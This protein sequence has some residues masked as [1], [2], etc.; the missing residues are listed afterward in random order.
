VSPATFGADQIV[1]IAT[2]L[3]FLVLVP[4]NA[5]FARQ[6]FN[7]QAPISPWHLLLI[8][9]RKPPLGWTVDQELTHSFSVVKQTDTYLLI[10]RYETLR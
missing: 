7:F 5:V 3:G 9:A 2:H 10:R 8:L 1:E 4:F 6:A